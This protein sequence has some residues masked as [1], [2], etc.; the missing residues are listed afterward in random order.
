VPEKQK[1]QRIETIDRESLVLPDI[2]MPHMIELLQSVGF[3]SAGFNGAQQI[4]WQEL[5]A[6]QEATGSSLTP[7][8]SE[9]I[10]RLSGAYASMLHQAKDPNC[11]QPFIEETED[12]VIAR[13]KA[14]D[15]FFRMPSGIRPKSKKVKP[16][17]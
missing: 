17:G 2:A 5:R 9:T 4:T 1:K 12:Q 3:C 6:W 7:W 10:Y 15:D 8:E 13:R 14:V 11:R 16:R